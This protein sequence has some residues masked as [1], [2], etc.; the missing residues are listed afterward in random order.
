VILAVFVC[1]DDWEGDGDR[2]VVTVWLIT[3]LVVTDVLFEGLGELVAL[4]A[5]L[6]VCVLH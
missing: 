2:L 4:D 5:W 6:N 1:V 3:W